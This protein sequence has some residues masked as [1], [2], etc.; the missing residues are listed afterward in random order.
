MCS[1]TK[2]FYQTSIVTWIYRYLND[3]AEKLRLL[4]VWYS[5][6]LFCTD[7]NMERLLP[8][9]ARPLFREFRWKRYFAARLVLNL[10]GGNDSRSSTSSVWHLSDGKEPVCRRTYRVRMEVSRRRILQ[11]HLQP[12]RPLRRCSTD[13]G[14]LTGL[15]HSLMFNLHVLL[16]FK[17]FLTQFYEVW[18]SQTVMD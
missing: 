12:A 5:K 2:L 1:I 13:Q 6:N 4:S 3:K 9:P 15:V 14:K 17:S 10:F 8:Y 11:K 7:F 16:L 18:S